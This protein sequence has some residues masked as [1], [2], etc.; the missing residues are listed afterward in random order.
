MDIIFDM[1]PLMKF[2][3]LPTHIFLWRFFLYGGWIPIAIVFLWGAREVWLKYVRTQFA[4]KQ[5]FIMLAIDIPKGNEQTPK[6]VENLFT[7]LSGAQGSID[8]YEK[9]WNGK[10]QLSFSL[11]IVSINGYTQFL[12]RTPVQF[13]NLVESAV[14]AQYPDAEIT[15][16]NDYTEG[17]PRKYPDDE[18]DIWGVEI[19][20]ALPSAYP[21][22]TYKDFED[23]TSAPGE[24]YK[25]TMASLMDLCSSLREGEQLWYQIVLI[26]AGFDW[27]E[28]GDKAIS[29][30]L[31][32]N[33]SKKNIVDKFADFFLEILTSFSEMIYPMW[34]DVK[35][36]KKE[37]EN[38]FKMFNL[39]PKERK[40][41]DAIQDK[42]SKLGFEFKMRMVY[43]A[44]KEIMNKG[45]V[46][47]GFF[48]WIKQFVSMD[49]NNLKPDMAKTATR[50]K[51]FFIDQV[52]NMKK[53][54][55]INNYIDREDWAGRLPGL[56]NIEELASIWHFPSEA[57]VKA[58]MIQ[59]APGRKAEPPATLPI[60]EEIIS[61]ELSGP[62]FD[63]ETEKLFKAEEKG[64]P[65]EN[66]PIK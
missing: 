14:Y 46:V 9:W 48:G 22:K 62:I 31:G 61:E 58:P 5:K 60:G 8:L 15:E 41:I 27:P 66:L 29:K 30:I 13:R 47:S 1:T 39:K 24:Q 52:A 33:T 11:E 37:D 32:E 45:K 56:L 16:V 34:G 6:A 26:P 49:L 51:Y 36:A 43:V 23:L 25:D 54:R 7:Y 55:L 42:V 28:I 53:N 10:F 40:Q 59:K 4:R 44:K 2:I 63:E 19:I 20:Q 18:W 3:S 57:T 64:A 17:I 12:I 35:D 50:G 21:I 65:P 38:M